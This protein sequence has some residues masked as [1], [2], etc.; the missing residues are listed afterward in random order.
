[1]WKWWT[2][3]LAGSG[4]FF[5][6][7]CRIKCVSVGWCVQPRKKDERKRTWIYSPQWI[8]GLNRN[9]QTVN[10]DARQETHPFKITVPNERLCL[11]NKQLNRFEPQ[12]RHLFVT[13]PDRTIAVRFCSALYCRQHPSFSRVLRDRRTTNNIETSEFFLSIHFRI[14][15]SLLFEQSVF[16]S[17]ESITKTHFHFVTLF[18]F[19]TVL[20]VRWLELKIAFGICSTTKCRSTTT[21]LNFH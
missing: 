7:F 2:G 11:A 3:Y 14:F 9:G 8:C 20:S 18:A 17:I 12:N 15:I 13:L 5:N 4:F 16:R 19:L 10:I 6:L 21:N 1:M